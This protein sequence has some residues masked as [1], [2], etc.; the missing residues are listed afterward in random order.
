MI[1]AYILTGLA[2]LVKKPPILDM[3][4]DQMRLM[5]EGLQVDGGKATRELGLSY[6][7]IRAA[8]EEQVE[9]W[10]SAAHPGGA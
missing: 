1:G 9:Q 8:L 5:K 10:G 6:M 3:S 7:P 4:V 2:N